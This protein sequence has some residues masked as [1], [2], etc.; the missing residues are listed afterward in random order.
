M[1][2]VEQLPN[3]EIREWGA[4]F[5]LEP[6][7]ADRDN[8]HAAQV[9]SAVVNGYSKRPIAPKHFMYRDQRSVAM[10]QIERMFTHFDALKDKGELDG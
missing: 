9:A 8:L 3:S 7:G 6:W 1:G 5:V 2:E 4:Y 10:E